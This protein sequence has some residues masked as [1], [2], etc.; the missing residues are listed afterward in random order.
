[1]T[2]EQLTVTFEPEVAEAVARAAERDG[3]SLSVWLERL[4]RKAVVSA[5]DERAR[6]LREAL[7]AAQEVCE[8]LGITDEQ[9]AW[10]ERVLDEFGIGR[11]VG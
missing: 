1:M 3:V 4:A 9:H 7:A 5:E 10:A 8:E 11:R 2:G 6:Q